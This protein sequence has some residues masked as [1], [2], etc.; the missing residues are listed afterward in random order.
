MKSMKL[1]KLVASIAI[2]A[3]TS[4]V[5]PASFA[6]AIPVF[7]NGW[8]VN[9]KGNITSIKG[10]SIRLTNNATKLT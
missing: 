6:N 8:S 7:E 4:V 5:I 10:D 1:K 9:N 3:M 2:M